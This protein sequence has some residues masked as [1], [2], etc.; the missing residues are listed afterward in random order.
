MATT[1]STGMAIRSGRAGASPAV[2]ERVGP[3]V[4]GEGGA[5]VAVGLGREVGETGGRAVGVRISE[6][7][8]GESRRGR[9]R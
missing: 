2:G 5:A 4:G 3:G 8:V 9:N 1:P 6:A 7:G